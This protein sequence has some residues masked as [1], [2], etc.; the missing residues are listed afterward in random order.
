[1]VLLQPILELI[2]VTN[3]RKLYSFQT[4]DRLIWYDRGARSVYE[5]PNFSTYEHKLVM[6]KFN[7]QRLRFSAEKT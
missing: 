2:R 4:W 3:I 7:I 5:S 6:E 1:M